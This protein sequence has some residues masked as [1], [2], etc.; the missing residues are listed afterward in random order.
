MKLDL[1]RKFPDESFEI[2]LGAMLSTKDYP[3]L[4]EKTRLVL[5]RLK[6]EWCR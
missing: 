1:G 3:D 5:E 6:E 2:Y 4:G